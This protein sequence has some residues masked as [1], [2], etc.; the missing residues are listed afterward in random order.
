MTSLQGNS[1]Q[2]VRMTDFKQR[3]VAPCVTVEGTSVEANVPALLN[4]LLIFQHYVLQSARLREFPTL[5]RSVGV[6]NTVSLLESGAL[7]I[8]LNP[9]TIGQSG[10][11]TV[12]REKPA[13][14][15]L[16]FSFGLVRAPHRNE[17]LVRSLQEV[18]RE[19][20]PELKP[21]DLLRLE[22]AILKAILPLP[23]EVGSPAMVSFDSDLRSNSP[24]LTQAL[25]LKLKAAGRTIDPAELSLKL[26]QIDDED[27]RCDS[28]L[29]K[30]GIS[31]EES[32]SIIQ[33]ALLAVGGL[34]L[35]IEDMRNHNALSGSIDDELPLFTGKFDFLT[36]HLSPSAQADSFSRVLKVCNLPSFEFNITQSFGMSRFLEVRRSTECDSFRSWLTQASELADEEIA[37]QMTSLR[38]RLGTSVHGLGGKIVRLGLSSALGAIPG[39]GLI[40]GPAFGALDTFVIDKIF[41]ASGPA[42]FLTRLYP[43]LFDPPPQLRRSKAA[44]DCYSLSKFKAR[45]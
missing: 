24:L 2:A 32:H 43:S 20:S 22:T 15:L 33:S 13:L 8:A 14:P 12:V 42:L 23:D 26:I 11:T 17:Y 1:T 19:L 9:T 35:R 45:V 40:A 27:F 28:N 10:Q 6:Q 21:H 29:D 31:T 18:R 37:A 16:S 3:L 38:T 39:V 34:N 25:A 41:R 44:P 5:V 36:D 4:R 7:S 30:L